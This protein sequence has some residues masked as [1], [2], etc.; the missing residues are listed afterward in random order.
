MEEAR[1]ETAMVV[2]GKNGGLRNL[3]NRMT[4]IRRGEA[5]AAGYVPH[6]S[7]GQVKLMVTVAGANKR[8]GERNALLIKTLFDG[9]FR[10]SEGL[11]I[12][13]IDIR[14]TEDGWVVHIIGK[15]GYGVAAIS[16]TV[17]A[18]LQS[19]CYRQKIPN[20][21]RIFPIT[22]SQAFRIVTET[23]DRAGIQKPTVARE[24]VGAVHILRHSGAIERLRMTG[25]FKSV[26]DQLRHKSALTTMLYFKTVSADESMVIQQGVNP[27]E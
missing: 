23:F 15:T 9:A 2:T 10:V 17:A 20:D 24:H 8:Y 6:L 12:R 4:A 19:Y 27:W 18:E 14:R 1:H 13:P 11:G 26:Q 25:N 5:A 3:S 21:E 7:V 22:R 16:S